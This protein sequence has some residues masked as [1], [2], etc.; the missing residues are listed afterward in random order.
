MVHVPYPEY[1]RVNH[2]NPETIL[3]CVNVNVTLTLTCKVFLVNL[4]KCTGI[5]VTN[6]LCVIK[7]GNQTRRNHNSCNFK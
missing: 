6:I 2:C 5:H 7:L 1:T 4:I 3:A